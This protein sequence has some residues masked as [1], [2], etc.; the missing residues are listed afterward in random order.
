M[1]LEADILYAYLKPTDWLKTYA[2][3]ILSKKEK[4][5]TSVATVI[6]IEIVSLRDFGSEFSLSVLP[7]LKSIKNLEILPLTV[8]IQ[9]KAAEVRKTYGLSIFDSIHAAICLLKKVKLISSDVIFDKIKGLE[10]IDPRN[11]LDTS[12]NL[13]HL[14]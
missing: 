5:I 9:E 1:Y 4:F 7:R 14:L 8:E 2:E 12:T 11:F 6:E 10:R 13:L 3:K